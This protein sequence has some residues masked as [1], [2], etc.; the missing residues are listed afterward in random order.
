[1]R[2][3][4]ASS[5]RA[6]WNEVASQIAADARS[7]PMRVPSG[8]RGVSVTLEVTSALKTVNGG[9]PTD[10][11]IAKALGA[12]NDPLGTAM[13]SRTPAQR[14]VAARIVDVKAF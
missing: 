2:V 4:D 14:V 8:A 9:T 5:G 1:M 12:I 11:P 3:L 10:S 13:D 6:E 7:S